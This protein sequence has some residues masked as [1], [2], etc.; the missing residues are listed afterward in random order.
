M[1][2]VYIDNKSSIRQRYENSF[3][4]E[5]KQMNEQS[6]VENYFKMRFAFSTKNGHIRFSY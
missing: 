3:P 2:I 6:Q 4:K 5:V 1:I